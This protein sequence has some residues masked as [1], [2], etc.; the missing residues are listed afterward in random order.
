M[1]ELLQ[2]LPPFCWRHTVLGWKNGFAQISGQAAESVSYTLFRLP[3]GDD[4]GMDAVQR[5]LMFEAR[6]GMRVM[7]L[8]L[9]MESVLFFW[10]FVVWLQ[11]DLQ[12]W[13][14]ETY[15]QSCFAQ[16]GEVTIKTQNASKSID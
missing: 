15:L 10:D 4:S 6:V 13:M 11:W 7:Y 5:R 8:I 14:D 12:H 9:T 16:T 2:L 3:L 1:A